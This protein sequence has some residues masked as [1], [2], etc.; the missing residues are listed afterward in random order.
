MRD[1]SSHRLSR[2]GD[3][4]SNAAPE[5]LPFGELGMPETRASV[6]CDLLHELPCPIDSYPSKGLGGVGV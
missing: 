5:S 2:V 6:V 4:P 1:A 3:T